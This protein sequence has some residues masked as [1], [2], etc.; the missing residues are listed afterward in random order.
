MLLNKKINI[1]SKSS[2]ILL[3]LSLAFGCRSGESVDSPLQVATLDATGITSTEITCRG[4]ISGK[5][6]NISAFGIEL[7]RNND[8]VLHQRTNIPSGDEFSFKISG[9][10]PASSYQFRAFVNDGTMHYGEM[11]NFT[12]KQPETVAPYVPLADPFILCH[13]GV[14]YAYGTNSDNGIPV[15]ISH[16]LVLW[17]PH[18]T[19]ALSK[20]NSYG[21]KWFWAPEVYYRPENKTFYM[22]YSAE[23]HICVAT[24]QSPLGPFTQKEKQPMRTTEKSIDNTLFI[25]DDGTPYLF[26]VRFTNGNVIWSVELESDW[27][28]VRENTLKMCVEA[29]AGW[30]RIQA[31]VAEGPSVIKRNGVYYLL[32][33]ANDYQSQDYGVGY[34]TA[35][36][37]GNTW[38]KAPENPILRKPN[39]E[40]VGTGHGAVFKDNDGNLRYVFHAHSDRVTIHPRKMYITGLVIDTDGKIRMDKDN[41]I[42]PSEYK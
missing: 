22:Y 24:S 3:M 12:T 15:Y 7:L 8:T 17:K 34:A 30:E 11:K 5:K 14:Y 28:T 21:D 20:E 29:V 16:D 26:F 4:S 2:L 39:A 27:V 18:S 9:L 1:I 38:E 23:E 25:D 37:L 33:S 42:S 35:S 41:I 36:A 19:L 40:L 10:I 32:Y 13:E 6:E 31:R